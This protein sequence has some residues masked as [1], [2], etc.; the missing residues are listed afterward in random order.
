MGM[1]NPFKS[2][3][4][5]YMLSEQGRKVS[6]RMPET[7]HLAGVVMIY[8]R[9]DPGSTF[10]DIVRGLAENYEIRTDRNHVKSAMVELK[11]KHCL[12]EAKE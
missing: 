5:R 2:K 9:G 3:P 12:T 10:D 1:F 6:E 11:N 4:R 8:L 7:T